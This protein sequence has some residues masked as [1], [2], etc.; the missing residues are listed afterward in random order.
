MQLNIYSGK[1]ICSESNGKFERYICY[2]NSHD[3]CM[4]TAVIHEH[5]LRF[6]GFE[7]GWKSNMSCSLK[8]VKRVLAFV[9]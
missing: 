8:T 6:Q 4:Q 9:S 5:I 2:T 3:W 1:R 7:W